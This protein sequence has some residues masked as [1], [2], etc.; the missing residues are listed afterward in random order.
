MILT[1]V[2]A[3]GAAQT[4]SPNRP[5]PNTAE[6][7][8]PGPPPT[9]EQISYLVGLVF[10]SQMHSTGVTPGNIKPESVVRGISDGLQ[11]KQPSATDQQQVQSYARSMHE[12]MLARNEAAAKDFLGRNS[13]IK[14]V[15]ATA[16][17]L[18]YK[19]IKAGDKKAAS[20][21]P[22]DIVTVDYRGKLIDGVEF[23]SSYS[24]GVPNTF[25]VNGVIKGWQEAL[26]MMKPGADWQLFVP[27]ELAYG[28][29]GQ[30]KIPPNSLLIFDVELKSVEAANAPPKAPPGTPPPRK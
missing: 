6:G 16:S 18:Q 22:T 28:P 13:K 11:G 15:V 21:G 25:P 12:A 17:G 19:I 30:S 7:A 3:L 1:A 20:P 10:G 2:A 29:R 5:P 24:R 23:D 14:G 4:P 9:P 8:D 26:V 27:P